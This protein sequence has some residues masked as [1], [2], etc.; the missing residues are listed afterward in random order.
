MSLTACSGGTVPIAIGG[1]PQ[2][3]PS[4]F[5]GMSARGW[6]LWN[7]SYWKPTGPG[8]GQPAPLTQPPNPS[9]LPYTWV[10]TWDTGY[11]LWADI[12]TSPGVY[13]WTYADQWITGAVSAGKKVQWVFAITP[14]F[15]ASSSDQL[16]AL[17]ANNTYLG[18]GGYP[19]STSPN[20]L[21]AAGNFITALLTRYNT[22]TGGWASQTNGSGTNW[23]VFG[24][25]IAS[26]EPWIEATFG[27]QGYEFWWGTVGQ[28]VDLCYTVRTA[29]KAVDSAIEVGSP[30]FNTALWAIQYLAGSGTINTGVTAGSLC[31]SFHFHTYNISLPGTIY[32][33]WAQ[34]L[35]SSASLGI[36]GWKSAMAGAAG[37]ALNVP[38][39]CNESGID[40]N[41]SSTDLTNFNAQPASYRYT[42]ILRTWMLHAAFGVKRWGAYCWD[43]PFCG[44][45]PAPYADLNGLPQAIIAFAKNCVGKTITS[46]SYVPGGTVTLN[47]SDTTNF[48]I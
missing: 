31:D 7:S 32:G 46:A 29:A 38:M 37:G 27:G 33:S 45:V 4:D 16:V 14:T 9:Y 23:S 15:Y 39:H 10:R 25:G 21:T 43:A 13:N 26:I 12:E 36:V 40:Y 42:F 41:F 5:L 1:M 34:D 3:I 8:G 28:L 11:L 19:A 18:G 6:P 17:G 24:K 47:F 2:T 20:G 30:S 22:S 35:V 48:T 44:G